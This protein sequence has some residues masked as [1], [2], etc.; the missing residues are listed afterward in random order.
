MDTKF[1]FHKVPGDMSEHMLVAA[2]NGLTPCGM[3]LILPPLPFFIAERGYL[4]SNFVCEFV[5]LPYVLYN[6][7]VR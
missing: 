2:A 6:R 4:N 1:I 7:N 5:R 3:G